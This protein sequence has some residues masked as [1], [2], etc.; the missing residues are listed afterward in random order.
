[1]YECSLHPQ[2]A[3]SGHLSSHWSDGRN[4]EH[5]LIANIDTFVSQFCLKCQSCVCGGACDQCDK[6]NSAFVF[7]H[8]SYT[9]YNTR[10]LYFF[11]RS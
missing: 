7:A 10:E 1:M 11:S 8:R 3:P 6:Q 9:S 5:L 4:F 2:M